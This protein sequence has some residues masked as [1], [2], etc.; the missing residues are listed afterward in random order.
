MKLNGLTLD[1][2][3]LECLDT[4][5]VKR[6]GTV[7]KNRMTINHRIK[8]IP[9]FCCLLLYL[10]LGTL[11]CLAVSAFNQLSDDKGLKQL[12][13]HILRQTTFVELQLWSNHDNGTA[14]VVN[15]LTKKIL[16]EATCLTLQRICKRL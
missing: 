14:R 7:Q 13:G 15:A 10:L 16:T 5:T 8:D 3:R 1:K 2:L 6:W 4:K 11:H 12:N 9:H